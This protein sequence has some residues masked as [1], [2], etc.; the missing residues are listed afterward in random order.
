MVDGSW[1][2][3][4]WSTTSKTG[5]TCTCSPG[6]GCTFSGNSLIY[7]LVTV[8]GCNPF[9]VSGAT[10]FITLGTGG[11]L[12][13]NDNLYVTGH[14][15]ITIPAGDSLIINGNLTIDGNASILVSGVLKISNN[16]NI[17]GNAQVSGTGTGS[18]GGAL[19]ITAGSWSLSAL[20]IELLNF[21]VSKNDDHGANINWITSSEINNNYFTVERTKDDQNFE[22][23]ATVLGAGNSN[24]ELSYKTLD[25][26]PL[27]G[28]SYYRLTQTD[29]NGQSHNFS[30]VPFDNNIS[31]DISLTLFP[32]ISNGEY[33]SMTTNS[34]DI[35]STMNV[36]IY[37]LYEKK[38]LIKSI[39]IEQQALNL[40]ELLSIPKLANGM[41]FLS[42]IINNNGYSFKFIIKN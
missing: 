20:P 7:N 30:L 5:P 18:Y 12:T 21:T 6:G 4:I 2:S 3:N 37:D 39:V 27:S 28:I 14:S 41:Y 31:N 22:T 8:N 38:I 19:T 17:S 35:G 40:T 25:P 42:A 24:V 29:F 13:D 16:V 32:N 26:N 11:K 15:T 33:L 1:A 23:V 34:A 10:A 9:T 36:S